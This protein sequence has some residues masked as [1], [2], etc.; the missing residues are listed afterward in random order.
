MKYTLFYRDGSKS[1]V[2]YDGRPDNFLTI[3]QKGRNLTGNRS[4]VMQIQTTHNAQVVWR[5][6]HEGPAATVQLKE[7]IAQAEAQNLYRQ[8]ITEV[9]NNNYD[10]AQEL[11]SELFYNIA[12]NG[13]LP[14]IGPLVY[15]SLSSGGT[16]AYSILS[17]PNGKGADFIKYQYS[18]QTHRMEEAA[19]YTGSNA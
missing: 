18:V 13:A 14:R 8:I 10:Y 3:R 7:D 9:Q 16:F 1:E 15:L 5:R 11:A 6:Q 17:H 4:G 2:E 12:K 19:R